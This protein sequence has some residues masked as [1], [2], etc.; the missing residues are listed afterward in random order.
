MGFED[1]L[2]IGNCNYCK[3]INMTEEEQNLIKEKLPHICKFYNKR[4]IHRLTS[5][6][7]ESHNFIYTCEECEKDNYKN[8]KKRR[9]K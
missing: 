4:V 1:F 5:R 2:Y 9:V 6:K 3:Y 8:F 7:Y